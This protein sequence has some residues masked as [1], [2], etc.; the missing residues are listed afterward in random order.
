MKVDIEMTL[1]GDCLVFKEVQ[2][3]ILDD[4]FSNIP[5]L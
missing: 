1:S 2:I 4:T 5:L 3:S